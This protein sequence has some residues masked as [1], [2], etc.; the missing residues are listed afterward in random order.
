[1]SKFMLKYRKIVTGILIIAVIG[2]I[3]FIWSNS[4]VVG[5][6]SNIESQKVADVIQPIVDPKQEIHKESFMDFIRK[7]AHFTEFMVL[8]AELILL[9]LSSKK[10]QIFTATFL[11]LSV[12]VIDEFIQSFSDR[13]DSVSDILLDFGGA[14]FG[15]AVCVGIYFIILFILKKLDRE[16]S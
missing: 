6:A 15:M 3:L 8:G 10:P 1:V 7:C 14:V 4:F 2:T 11:A 12:A 16:K 9:K 13:T 5:K